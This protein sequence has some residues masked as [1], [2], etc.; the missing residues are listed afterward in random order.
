MHGKINLKNAK[1][2]DDYT[3][4]DPELNFDISQKYTRAYLSHLFRADEML[5][6]VIATMHNLHFII[7]L[8]DGAREAILEGK[9]EMY[10]SNFLAKYKS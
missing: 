6:A 9:F 2:R 5:G 7:N 10:K 8:V 1:F 3:P 4:L